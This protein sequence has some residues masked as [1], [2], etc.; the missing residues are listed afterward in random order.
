MISTGIF[1]YP[2]NLGISWYFTSHS[3]TR[4]SKREEITEWTPL[5]HI[6]IYLPS[7]LMPPTA[8]SRLWIAIL[9]YGQWVWKESELYWNVVRD[10]GY[11]KSWERALHK[12]IYFCAEVTYTNPSLWHHEVSE[13]AH[14]L[15][16]KL[17]SVLTRLR[18]YSW[19]HD[20]PPNFMST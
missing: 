8:Y 18:W 11:I 5:G 1:K 10:L 9:I 19:L 12:N 7:I 16:G 4:P 14:N 6:K 2:L 20:V 3:R 17:L 13:I 15:Q